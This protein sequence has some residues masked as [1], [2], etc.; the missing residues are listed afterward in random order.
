LSII[1]I[2]RNLF[3]EGGNDGNHPTSKPLAKRFEEDDA[4]MKRL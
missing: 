2:R 1:Q 3:Q 4:L